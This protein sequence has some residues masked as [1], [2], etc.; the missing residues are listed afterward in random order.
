[1]P[2]KGPESKA[3]VHRHVEKL[4]ALRKEQRRL[5]QAVDNAVPRLSAVI[6]VRRLRAKEASA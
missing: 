6:A 4:L 3:T 1:M 2:A 5:T